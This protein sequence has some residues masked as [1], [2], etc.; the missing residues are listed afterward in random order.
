MLS[1]VLIPAFNEAENLL[2]VIGEVKNALPG[3]DIII[4][5]DGSRDKTELIAKRTGVSVISH[6]VNMGYG[7]TVQTGFKYAC[8]KKYDRIILLDA[9]GQHN[10]KD[11]PAL[12]M[13]MDETQADMVIGSRFLN[14]GQ[15][16][17]SLARKVG[18]NFFSFITFFL[19]RNRFSDITSGFRVI[20]KRALQFLSNNYPVDFPDAE[21]IIMLLLNGFKVAEAPATF[22]MRTKGT[23]MFSIPRKVY[24]PFKVSLAILIVV[25]RLVLKKEKQSC[26]FE[27][28]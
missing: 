14:K 13:A 10:A 26:L 7:V 15:Y 6:P 1:C 25:I 19:T 16:K 4:I 27:D 22:R 3:F 11:V 12:L 23:S 8:S 5:N 28:N 2:L 20:N 21:V 17:T 24:Y 18:K 9:D